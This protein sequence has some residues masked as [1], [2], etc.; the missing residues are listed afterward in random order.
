MDYIT[1]NLFG[2]AIYGAQDRKRM[3]LKMKIALLATSI[4]S[5]VIPDIDIQWA[6]RA[7]GSYLI[8]H[9][10]ITHSFLMAPVW[11]ALFFGLAVL[12]L[13][14]KDK[15]IF[16]TGLIGVLL[17]IV[18]DWTNAWG[19]GL[20]E[21]FTSRKYAGGFIPNKGYV[22]WCF[23][24]FAALLL[25]FFRGHEG[26]L[27]AIRSFWVLSAVYVLFQI[28]HSVYVISDLKSQGY[29]RVAIRADRWPGGISY[30]AKRDDTVVEGRSELGGERNRIV[31]SYRTDPVDVDALMQDSRARAILLFAPFVAAQDLGDRIRLFDPRFAGRLGMLE[32]VVPKGG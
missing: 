7:D 16:Y 15:R 19:T 5:S 31:Q 8:N 11:A 23:A 20:F 30:Y 25:P 14:V 17:H 26:R 2:V 10:G 21:P 1:H 22:F 29:D 32:A 12:L 9:R 24:A 3:D 28:G 18:S 4:G 6:S 13:R 27:R